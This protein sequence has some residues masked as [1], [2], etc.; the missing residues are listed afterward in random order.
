MVK[1]YSLGW[2]N[3][4][5]SSMHKCLVLKKCLL[6]KKP[7]WLYVF[8]QCLIL[9]FNHDY[10]SHGI[11]QHLKSCS[12]SGSLHVINRSTR[13]KNLSLFQWW[14]IS[15]ILPNSRFQ[16]RM[17]FVGESW[18]L[19]K[20]QS[21]TPKPCLQYVILSFLLVPQLWTF[22]TDCWYRWKHFTHRKSDFCD[23]N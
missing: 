1:N 4:F 7:T 10:R 6:N 16:K 20:I 9:S 11:R 2:P 15:E 3:T 22:S 8:L 12:L 21:K 18:L 23:F 13:L 5:K 19:G 14:S 17:V